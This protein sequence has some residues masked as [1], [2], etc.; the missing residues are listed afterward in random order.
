MDK[1]TIYATLCDTSIE[2]KLSPELLGCALYEG[3]AHLQNLAE[4]LA[5]QHGEATALSFFGLM[6]EDVQAFWIDIAKQLIEHS[7]Q[8]KKNKGSYCILSEQETRR[9]SELTK[10][11]SK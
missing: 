3:T 10:L 8:W 5:R 2:D 1:N 9:L 7:K 11:K 4:K 6:G